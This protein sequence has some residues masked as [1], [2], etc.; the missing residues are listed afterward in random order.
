MRVEDLLN[1]ILDDSIIHLEKIW[2][3][4]VKIVSK[5][6]FDYKK[7]ETEEDAERLNTIEYGEGDEEETLVNRKKRRTTIHYDERKI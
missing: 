1:I 3:E 4:L 2:I 7:G 6:L 5:L